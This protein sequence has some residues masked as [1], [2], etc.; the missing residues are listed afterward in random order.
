MIW[1]SLGYL[2]STHP[3]IR[4]SSPKPL[5]LL[6]RTFLKKINFLDFASMFIG[7][8]ALRGVACIYLM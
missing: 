3:E 5:F 7:I 1:C 4:N 2:M 8:Q 6:R